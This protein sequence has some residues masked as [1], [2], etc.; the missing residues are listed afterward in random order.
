MKQIL[1]IFK[2]DV[3]LFCGEI[4]IVLS[5]VAA[6]ASIYYYL[7]AIDPQ[8]RSSSFEAGGKLARMIPLLIFFITFA[9]ILLVCRVIQAE[10]LAG[11]TQFWI[12][13][14]YEWKKLLTAKLLFI[15]TF[16]YLPSIAALFILKIESGLLLHTNLTRGL[17]GG[18]GDF[19][20]GITSFVLVAAALATVTSSI[21]R[22]MGGILL[23]FISMTAVMLIPYRMRPDT[24]AGPLSVGLCFVLF[25]L[26]CG[27]AILLQYARRKT[28]ISIALLIAIPVLICAIHLFTPER[29]PPDRIQPSPSTVNKPT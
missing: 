8:F 15:V 21:A 17:L 10:R 7:L 27:A 2:K 20:Y 26:L 11:D 1:H 28:R 3:R 12:T 14:P 13:R 5:L 29:R 22:M 23:A 19:L 25:Y 18:I 4:V 6:C 16:I 9:W 24:V